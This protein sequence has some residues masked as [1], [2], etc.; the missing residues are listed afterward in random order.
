[1]AIPRGG[2]PLVTVN[3]IPASR[4][5][6]TASTARFVS[7][8][9]C[10]TRVPST[11]A[12]TILIGLAVFSFLDAIFH[13]VVLGTP[14]TSSGKV[15]LSGKSGFETFPYI[16]IRSGPNQTLSARLLLKANPSACSATRLPIKRAPGHGKSLKV[17]EHEE[18]ARV[19]PFH[20]SFVRDDLDVSVKP[21]P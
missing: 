12:I 9:S 21:P 18:K 19:T 10:V 1:M 11:S 16:R 6:E 4:K 17:K 3:W 15:P 14:Q 5:R 7:T 20:R 13:L 2:R 8:F